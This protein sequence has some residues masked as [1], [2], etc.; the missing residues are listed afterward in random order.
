[1]RA[2]I[3]NEVKDKC[4][5]RNMRVIPGGLTP[6]LQA[7]GIGIYKTFKDLLY[8]EMNAWKDSDKVEYTR[9]GKPRMPSIEVVCGWVRKAWHNTECNTV[10]NSIAAAGFADSYLDWHIARRV[11]RKIS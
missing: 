1:M 6:Y 8:L 3:S 11:Q 2:N 9:F 7:G 5:A 4:A 10:V